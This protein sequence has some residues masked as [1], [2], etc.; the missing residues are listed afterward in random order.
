M[1]FLS[2]LGTS[3]FNV[4]KKHFTNQKAEF[5]QHVIEQPKHKLLYYLHARQKISMI[6]TLEDAIDA[7]YLRHGQLP[8]ALVVSPL[9]RL[10][11]PPEEWHAFQ[12]D[13]AHELPP[14]PLYTHTEATVQ[15]LLPYNAVLQRGYI[16]CIGVD[17]YPAFNMPML[18][19]RVKPNKVQRMV[20]DAVQDLQTVMMPAINALRVSFI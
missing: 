13:I 15:P 18:L 6:E 4:V 2:I 20:A 7:F 17:Q 5:V 8:A 12:Y 3:V 14:V 19:E 10:E 9:E 11:L 16:F 1:S